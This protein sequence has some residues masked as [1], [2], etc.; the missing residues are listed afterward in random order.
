MHRCRHRLASEAFGV[1]FVDGATNAASVGE[2][3]DERLLDADQFGQPLAHLI[4]TGQLDE[5]RRAQLTG[6]GN[7]RVVGAQFFHH[8]FV[9][10]GALDAQHLLNLVVHR[11]AILEGN[12]HDGAEV[13]ATATLHFDDLVATLFAHTLIGA[14]VENVVEGEL[15]FAGHG[16]HRGCLLVVGV[17]LGVVLAG[18]ITRYRARRPWR[19]PAAGAVVNRRF[20]R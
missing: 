12:R 10:D 18:V 16:R 3:D 6:L 9:G 19:P 7:H 4:F 17:L 14:V 13:Q 5:E 11:R 8:A 1:L 15:A 2:H 20:A